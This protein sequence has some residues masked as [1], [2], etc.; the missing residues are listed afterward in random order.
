MKK[1]KPGNE[2]EKFVHDFRRPM[3][4]NFLNDL[5]RFIGNMNLLLFRSFFSTSRSK[6]LFYDYR[7]IEKKFVWY[8]KKMR[9]SLKLDAQ[10]NL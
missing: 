6:G 4:F 8:Q 9:M 5:L 10:L 7:V 2:T 1:S 3:K